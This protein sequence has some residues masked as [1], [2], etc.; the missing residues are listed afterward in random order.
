MKNLLIVL[1]TLIAVA[2][3][4]VAQGQSRDSLDYHY[5]FNPRYVEPGYDVVLTIHR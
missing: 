1:C 5:P 2:Q 4:T 3:T